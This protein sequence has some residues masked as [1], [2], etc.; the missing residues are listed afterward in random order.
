MKRWLPLGLSVLV[1]AGCASV[2]MPPEAANTILV[3]VPSAAI[4]IWRPKLRMKDGQLAIEGYVFRQHEA[5][6]TAESHVDLVFTDVLGHVL[7]VDTMGFYP[8]SL[9]QTLRL[10]HPLAYFLVPIPRLP[11]GTRAIEVRGHD[12]PHSP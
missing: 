4:D 2:P 8:R 9:P 5:G 3:P 10:P 6:T 12:G 11:V 7:A 1:F